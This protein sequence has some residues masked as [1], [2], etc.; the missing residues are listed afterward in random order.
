MLNKFHRIVTLV[1][2]GLLDPDDCCENVRLGDKKTL[3]PENMAGK[4]M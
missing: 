1:G 4:S 2:F 3:Y